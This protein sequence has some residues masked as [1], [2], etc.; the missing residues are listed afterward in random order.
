M[1]GKEGRRREGVGAHSGKRDMGG[2]RGKGGR[3]ESMGAPA[4]GRNKGVGA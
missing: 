1:V 2:V 3:R 4:A